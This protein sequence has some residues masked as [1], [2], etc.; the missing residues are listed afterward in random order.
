MR[1]KVQ[2]MNILM[3]FQASDLQAEHC[4][5]QNQHEAVVVAGAVHGE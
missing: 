3:L 5:Q 2:E 1:L 4:E